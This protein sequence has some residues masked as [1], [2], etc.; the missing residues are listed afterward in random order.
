MQWTTNNFH[1]G[2]GL[3]RIKMQFRTVLDVK[4]VDVEKRRNPSKHYVYLIN[5]TYSD[6]TSHIVYR[7]YS[8]FFDLQMQILDKFPIEGGQKDPKK[9]IIP[10]L[11]GNRML[12]PKTGYHSST[13]VLWELAVTLPGEARKGLCPF[14]V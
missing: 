9:R 12:T 1:I 2:Q 8:K 14:D 7:R 10:F 5:V 6:N 3:C 13:A 4:V 11:P